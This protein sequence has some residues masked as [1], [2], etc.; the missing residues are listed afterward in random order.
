MSFLCSFLVLPSTPQSSESLSPPSPST[1][2]QK[3]LEDDTRATLAGTPREKTSL[4]PRLFLLSSDRPHNRDGLDGRES[5][6]HFLSHLFPHQNLETTCRLLFA[7]ESSFCVGIDTHVLKE[8]LL[9]SGLSQRVARTRALAAPHAHLQ[10]DG[11]FTSTRG[12][13]EKGILVSL[14]L[15]FLLPVPMSAL[16]LNRP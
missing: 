14:R 15:A 2:T 12:A 16:A 9:V 10:I 11:M 3:H 5:P 6:P 8:G 1:T 7:R 13:T 4:G